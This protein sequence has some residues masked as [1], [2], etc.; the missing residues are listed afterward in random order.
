M[1]LEKLTKKEIEVMT[2]IAGKLFDEHIKTGDRNAFIR[3]FLFG[4]IHTLDEIGLFDT[5]ED[6][7]DAADDKAYEFAKKL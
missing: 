1:S 2:E 3:G 4:R 7:Q 5:L 6:N